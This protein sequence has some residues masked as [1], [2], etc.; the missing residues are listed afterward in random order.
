MTDAHADDRNHLHHV[1]RRADHRA[2][3]RQRHLADHLCGHRRRPAARDRRDSTKRSAPNDLGRAHAPGRWLRSWSR[4]S[5]FVV[6]V[7]RAQRRI[8]VQYAQA[9]RRPPRATAGQSTHLPLRVN[10]G[11]VIPVIFASSILAVPADVRPRGRTRGCGRSRMHS[12][13]GDPLYNLLYVALHHLL[14]LLLHVDHLQPDRHGGQHA[15]VRRLHS[16]HPPGQA[17]RRVHRHDPRRGSLSS[18]PCT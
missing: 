6:F 4:W 8:P 5:A 1:A 17:Y 7:E 10:T 13:L 12:R 14:L 3:Y 11:G 9:R 2:R 16:G 15:E 18:A